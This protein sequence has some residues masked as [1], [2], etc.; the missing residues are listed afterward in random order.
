MVT[1]QDIAHRSFSLALIL[2]FVWGETREPE[3]EETPVPKR[4]E[5]SVSV[6]KEKPEYL[7]EI[8]S[9]KPGDNMTFTVLYNRLV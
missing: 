1:K 3:R 8:P 2:A 9:L 6:R 7:K 5:T 4:K